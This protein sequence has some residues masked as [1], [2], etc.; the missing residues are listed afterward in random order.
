MMV[1][2]ASRRLVMSLLHVS[3]LGLLFEKNGYHGCR[4]LGVV[5]IVAGKGSGYKK[6]I[7]VLGSWP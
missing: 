5:T 1:I 7:L 6:F 2:M 3:Q 4:E